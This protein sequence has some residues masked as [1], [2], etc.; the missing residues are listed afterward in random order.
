M[1]KKFLASINLNGNELQ[2]ARIHVL[3]SDPGSPVEGQIWYNSTDHVLRYRTNGS[4]ITIGSG[5]TADNSALLQGQ[6]GAYYLSRANHT[7]TQA[8][9]TVS[10][11]QAAI[12]GKAATSH[13]HVITDI[14]GLQAALDAKSATGHTHVSAN[15]TDFNTAVDA[16]VAGLTAGAPALLDTLDE[17]AAA[18]GDDANFASTVTTALA[19]KAGKYATTIGNGAATSIVVTHNLNTEDIDLTVREVSTKAEV[20]VEWA[21]TTVNTATITFTVAPANNSLRVLVV[22]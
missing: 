9:S 17:L 19:T 13:T 1:A 8:I 6:N 2:N 21:P 22:G 11:L 4:T 10:G 18:L 20:G 15:I 5:G 16:R 12:D 3:A 7:G 14:T